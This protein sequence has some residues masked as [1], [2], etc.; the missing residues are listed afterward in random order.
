V[1]IVFEGIDGSGKTTQLDLLESKL[2]R[3]RIRTARF[4]EP[5]ATAIGEKI[6]K[7]LL[8]ARNSMSAECELFLYMA[9]RAQLVR[10]RI[11]PLLASGSWVLCDRYLYSSAAYQGEAGGVGIERVMRMGESAIGRTVPDR[12]FLLDIDP[13]LAARR[14]AGKAADRIE[15]RGLEYQNRVRRGFLKLRRRRG[16]V[17]LDGSRP[18][19][20]IHSRVWNCLRL[21]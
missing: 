16:F 10:E 20:E 6:R 19:E 8:D 1:F 3:L 17:V 12:V 2:R 11:R 18:P 14:R 13:R 15:K 21:P 4:R 7:I 5:G 9:A